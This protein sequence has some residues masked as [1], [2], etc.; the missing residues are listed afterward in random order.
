MKPGRWLVDVFPI[1]EPYFF[2]LHPSTAHKASRLNS[3][4]CFVAAYKYRNC[5]S[6]FYLHA[7]PLF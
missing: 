6:L 5:L 4:R 7:I 1:R 2:Y 3:L